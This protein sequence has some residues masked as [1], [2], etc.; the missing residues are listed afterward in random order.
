MQGLAPQYLNDLL[1]KSLTLH[2]VACGPHL[3]LENADIFLHTN[4]LEFGAFLH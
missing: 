4:T 2:C 1:A 3:I